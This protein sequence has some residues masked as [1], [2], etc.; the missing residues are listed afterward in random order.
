MSI[1]IKENLKLDTLSLFRDYQKTRNIQIRNQ[2]LELNFGLARKEAYH[3]VNKCPESYEDLLQV[4]SLGL[5]R[6]IE[7]FDSEKGHAF[8]SFALPYIRGEIQ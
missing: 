2:I 5:I 1:P 7:R 6:A 4:G 8:S 3:W